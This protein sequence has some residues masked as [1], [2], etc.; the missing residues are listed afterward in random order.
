A[1]GAELQRAAAARGLRVDI[2]VAATRMAALV[3]AL[4]RP[5]LTVVD[6]G[7]EADVLASIPLGILEKINDDEPQSAQ[8]SQ[9]TEDQRF[10]A[11]S[12]ISAVERWGVKTLG[13]LAALPSADLAARPG[14]PAPA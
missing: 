13:D 11:C 1:I 9:N 10:S 14:P 2:A 6:P 12:A 8:R 3:L 4:A 7:E 5:G